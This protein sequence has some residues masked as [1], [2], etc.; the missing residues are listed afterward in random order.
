MISLIHAASMT[1]T[2]FAV[3]ISSTGILFL[4]SLTHAEIAIVFD[5]FM[6]LHWFLELYVKNVDSRKNI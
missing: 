4:S 1:Y 6:V 3:I 2:N 5:A